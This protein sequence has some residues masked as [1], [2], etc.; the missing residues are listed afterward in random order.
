MGNCIYCNKSAGFFKKNHKECE[1]K[2]KNALQFI[3]Q[4]SEDFFNKS[5]KTEI[6]ILKNTAK[7]SFIQIS[8]LNNILENT[9]SEFLDKFLDDGLLSCE[10]EDLLGEYMDNFQLSQEILDKNDSMSKTIRASILRK[11][12][13]GEELT[14]R[15]NI[16]GKLPF[17]FL[18]NEKLIW[19]FQNV[20][21]NEQRIKT[22]YEGK[23]QGVSLR[24]AK[25]VY[26]RTGNFKGKPV[27]TMNIIP[28]AIGM[29]AITYKH[30]YFS[31][32]LKNFRIGFDKIITVDSY[33]NAI[34]IQKDGVSAKPLIFKNVD[35]WFCYN[36]IQNI[37]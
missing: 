2:N 10:E 5:E 26:Y 24:I 14:Q 23:S 20:E 33:S 37:N 8:E 13:N 28:I 22:T 11:L 31:S 12:L 32:S 19:L 15:I 17:K 3:K 18:K 35:G 7:E 4:K 34:G 30:L 1:L 21:L 9:Y 25:G 16:S 27:Q 29:L 6:E 36:F